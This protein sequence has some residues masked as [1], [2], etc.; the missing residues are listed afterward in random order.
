MSTFTHSLRQL[1]CQ[2]QLF[3]APW[4]QPA[5]QRATF[6]LGV[7]SIASE[8]SSTIVEPKPDPFAVIDSSS[9]ISLPFQDVQHARAVPVS[10]SY[11][12]REPQFNEMYLRIARL[13]TKYHTL[14]TLPPSAAPPTAW[15]KLDEMRSKLGEPIKASHYAKVIRVAKRLNQIETSLFPEEVRVALEDFKRDI[16]P[17]MNVPHEVTVDKFGRAVGVG[18][19][20]ESTARA[21]VVEGTGEVLINGKTLSQAFGRVHDRESAV[22]AL[23]ATERLDKYNVWALVEGGGTTGQAEALTLAVAKALIV[24]EPALK[25]A[26]RKAGCITRDPRTVERKK[27]GHVKARKMPAWVKR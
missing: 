7:R 19:R 6:P 9:K 4:P 5:L 20:K 3:R 11:F 2:G 24:H 12:S 25:T 22:W 10:A 13:L 23:Q 26:L 27:H 18:K 16:N 1:R 21:W 14:P 8:T 15:V 17:F